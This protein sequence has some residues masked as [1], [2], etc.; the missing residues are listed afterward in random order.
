M[1]EVRVATYEIRKS[2]CS[3]KP[4]GTLDQPTVEECELRLVQPGV[5]PVDLSDAPVM[6]N[7]TVNA[8]LHRMSNPDRRFINNLGSLPQ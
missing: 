6:V 7:N 5:S 3:S 8:P 2:D 1:Q 4:E